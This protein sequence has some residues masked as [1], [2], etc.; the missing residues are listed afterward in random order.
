MNSVFVF[1]LCIIAIVMTAGVIQTY[2]KQGKKLPET[3]NDP[4]E[5][6]AT[7][8]RLEKRIQVLE[9]II[10]EKHVDLKQTIDNL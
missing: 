6:L 3:D 5:M 9:R 2:I 4:D 1:V 8:D 7:I 10:T